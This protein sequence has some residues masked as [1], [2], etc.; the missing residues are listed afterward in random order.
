MI[1]EKELIM[2][3]ENFLQDNYDIE[4]TIP[5]KINNR[6]KVRLGRYKYNGRTDEPLEIDLAGYLIKYASEDIIYKVLKHELIH[7]AL[8]VHGL[9]FDDGHPYFEDE[10]V[11]HD[12]VATEVLSIGLYYRFTCTDCEKVIMTK[13]RKVKENIFAYRS[14]C[15][16]ADLTYK[17]EVILNGE[18]RKVLQHA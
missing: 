4:L 9:P 13:D 11:K 1:T 15:C 7:Y 16:K 12:S 14:A 18:E 3:A 5:I 10:L 6:L 2:Y 8:H 17:D